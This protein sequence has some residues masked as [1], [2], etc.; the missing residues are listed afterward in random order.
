VGTVRNGVPSGATAV[1]AAAI[2]L[3]AV[4][5]AVG[6]ELV[7]F[8]HFTGDIAED[9]LVRRFEHDRRC[10]AS[11]PGFDP[12]ADTETP[13][14]SRLQSGKIE[15]RAWRDEVVS[16]GF[17]VLEK[18]LGHDRTQFVSAV[19]V[20]MLVTAAIPQIPCLWVLIAG[21]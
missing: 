18:L 14:I 4:C 9:R 6:L 20:R 2:G 16:L 21:F 5:P 19:V 13:P 3:A 17:G 11:I 10:D 12:A 15:P 1:I 7:L 8:E